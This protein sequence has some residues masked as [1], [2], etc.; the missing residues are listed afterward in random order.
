MV[1]VSERLTLTPVEVAEL[2]GCSRGT[3]YR[4]CRLGYWPTLRIGKKV[5]IPRRAVERMLDAAEARAEAANEAS[6]VECKYL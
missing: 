4:M 5:V 2:L 3:A 1:T 6:R